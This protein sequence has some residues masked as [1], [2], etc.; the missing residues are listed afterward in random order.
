MQRPP[1]QSA[2]TEPQSQGPAPHADLQDEL[3]RANALAALDMAIDL[4]EDLSDDPA[5]ASQAARLVREAR[6]I[7]Q[8]VRNAPP[9]Q[10]PSGIASRVRDVQRDV[11]RASGEAT[12]VATRSHAL[13]KAILADTARDMQRERQKVEAQIERTQAAIVA[14]LSGGQVDARGSQPA[15]NGL[16]EEGDGIIG[17][18]V[19][20]LTVASRPVR[21]RV[22]QTVRGAEDRVVSGAVGAAAATGIISEGDGLETAE[23]MVN[24]FQSGDAAERAYEGREM[25][26]AAARRVAG[27][28][29]LGEQIRNAVPELRRRGQ[30]GM[31]Q[32]LVVPEHWVIQQLERNG[33]FVGRFNP[34]GGHAANAQWSDTNIRRI[35]INGDGRLSANEISAAMRDPQGT[36]RQAAAN[37][38]LR[39]AAA[40]SLAQAGTQGVALQGDGALGQRDGRVTIDEVM[41]TLQRRGVTRVDQVDSVEELRVSLGGAPQ[42]QGRGQQGGGQQRATPTQTFDQVLQA[43]LPIFN[44]DARFKGMF[45]TDG[46]NRITVSELRTVLRDR[47]GIDSLSD[48]RDRDGDGDIDRQDLMRAI[49]QTRPRARQ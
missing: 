27:Q 36:V 20:G 25:V 47:Y 42:T 2:P 29:F 5:G 32:G 39:E 7:Q 14:G 26:D 9:G 23:G 1:Q 37:R 4:A 3:T 19:A 6:D 24:R 33:A 8:L 44:G 41:A 49:A 46:N 21:E 13:E 12:V 28:T 15:D 34:L 10:L 43:A 48:I 45:D 35:D 38:A 31:L 16:G 40:R 17:N 18:V 11:Q 30:V 22:R